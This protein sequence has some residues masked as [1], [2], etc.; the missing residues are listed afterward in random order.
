LICRR[1]NHLMSGYVDIHAH[2]LPVI[3]D[4]PRDLEQSVA[5]A[6]AA[7]ESGIGTMAATPHLNPEFPNVNVTELA[8]RCGH[9]R[10]VL[11]QAQIPLTLVS[12]A[13]ISVSWALDANDEQLALASYGQ[14]GTDLLIE[15]PFAQVVGFERFLEQLQAKGFRVT[16]AHPERNAQFQRDL[17]PLQRLVDQ[18]VLLQVNA[19]SLL[20]RNGSR[21]AAQALLTAGLASVIASDGHRAQSWRPVTRLADGVRMAAGLVGPERAQW[22]A[23]AVPR[24]ITEGT[25]LPPEPPVI[26]PQRRRLFRLR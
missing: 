22:M 18:G 7:V 17:A 23:E 19:E 12:G 13:E 2:L 10:G 4:G 5:M 15:T 24:A 21:G 25:E 9:L 14:R 8:G 1:Q 20:G 26:E 6:R 3:D 11:E 16:L